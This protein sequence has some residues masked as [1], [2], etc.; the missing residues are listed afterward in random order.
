MTVRAL[1][2]P[3]IGYLLMG[4]AVLLFARAASDKWRSH[5]AFAATLANYGLFPAPLIAPLSWLVLL[6]EALVAT[7]LCA[8][9]T[10]APAAIGG[11]LLLGAYAAAIGVNLQRGRR[12]LDCGCDGPAVR[13]P[14][15]PWMVWRN[16]LLAA[17]V[18]GLA[19]PWAPRPLELVDV[20]TMGS[21]ATVV[22]LIYLAL[23]ALL[24]GG[25]RASLVPSVG[26]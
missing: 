2:D 26:Q 13:R 4:P 16:L 7:S 14:I 25:W 12:D 17:G 22:V 6:M 10:R 8:T 11:A 1:L 18:A 20:L 3:A 9:S 21:G 24:A 15:A 5:A 19:V 23:D